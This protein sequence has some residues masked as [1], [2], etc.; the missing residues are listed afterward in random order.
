MRATS[1]GASPALRP[2]STRS[3][4]HRLAGSTSRST[5]WPATTVVPA[6]ASRAVT[7]AAA[8]ATSFRLPRC[9]ASA[10]RSAR[11]RLRSCAVPPRL[12]WAACS[13]ALADATSC[14]R[15]SSAP[16]LMKACCARSSLRLRFAAASARRACASAT[17]APAACCV[18]CA[19]A[20]DASSAASRWSRS[21]GSIS[22]SAWP[23]CTAWPTSTCTPSTR[24]ATVGPTSQL[25]RAS[26]WPMP[27]ISGVTRPFCTVVTCTFTGASGP[28][29]SATNAS[30]PSSAS[31]KPPSSKRREVVGFIIVM[32][33][34]PGGVGCGWGGRQ[35]RAGTGRTRRAPAGGWPPP[36]RSAATASPAPA[37][38]R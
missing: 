25:R 10:A 32:R 3:L 34:S 16:A 27:K 13:P 21:T 12:A 36:G 4:T 29:R 28:V 2:W 17:C 31:A 7:T 24:P 14:A 30:A 38:S 6:S 9:C 20:S 26:T 37:P 33:G 11:S 22:A 19:R 1:P 15:A 8:G 5:A 18:L 23:G 35:G